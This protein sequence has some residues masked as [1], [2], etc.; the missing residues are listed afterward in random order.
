M[1]TVAYETCLKGSADMAGLDRTNIPTADFYQFRAAH[2]RRLQTAWEFDYWPELERTDKRYYRDVWVSGTSY[3]A[4]TATLATEVY[5]PQTGLYYQCLKATSSVAP[6]NA[7]DVT[8]TTN[9]ADSK[10]SYSTDDFSASTTYAVGDQVFYPTT[11][12]SYQLHT[13]AVAG[14]V[15]TDTT[16]WGIL[17]DFDA[18]IAY[19]QTGKTA[20][21]NVIE[22]CSANPR[23]TTRLN[24]YDWFLSENGVQVITPSNFAY[25]TYKI[26]TVRLTGDVWVSG[27]YGVGDQVYYSATGVP[28]NFYDCIS[29]TTT[30]APTDTTKWTVLSIPLIFQRYLEIGGYTDWLRNNGQN[31]R[32]DGNEILAGTELAN[33]S[34]LLVA[35]QSQRKRT[36]VLSR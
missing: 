34:A 3:V 23:T 18:Y 12:R 20:I 27:V 10:T 28:G 11:D 17:T 30:E 4:S 21:G 25:I 2:D 16:K 15:P 13:A 9:W 36:L 14:T 7:S 8:N 22:V 31:D 5:F 24:Q 1:R 29:A 26:R 32:A 19:S 33:Q 6:A 35:G